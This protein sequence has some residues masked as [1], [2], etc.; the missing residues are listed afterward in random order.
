MVVELR[1]ILPAL[2]MLDT[3]PGTFT[4]FEKWDMA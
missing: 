3:G 1:K 4:W 2:D